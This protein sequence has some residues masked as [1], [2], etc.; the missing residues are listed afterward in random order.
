[1]SGA[2]CPDS[3]WGCTLQ[4]EVSLLQCFFLKPG[5]HMIVL[6]T[7]VVSKKFRDDLDDP[8]VES[9]PCA[10]LSAFSFDSEA[11]RS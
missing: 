5:F 10:L 4:A 11:S 1:M 8:D 2:N 6:T 3:A 7:P 9:K